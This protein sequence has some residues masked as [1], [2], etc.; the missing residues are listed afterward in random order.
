MLVYFAIADEFVLGYL[1]FH[2]VDNQVDNAHEMI[3]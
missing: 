3:C 2:S 1:I